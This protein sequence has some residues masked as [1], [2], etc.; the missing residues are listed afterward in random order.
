M[1][2]VFSFQKE[3]K[4]ERTVMEMLVAVVAAAGFY[5]FNLPHVHLYQMA[6]PVR[7][8]IIFVYHLHHADADATAGCNFH[9]D[10]VE[11]MSSSQLL[12]DRAQPTCAQHLQLSL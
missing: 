10:M 3:R 6:L 12:W 7:Y 5:M 11:T 2:N 1:A 8:E 4:K 9:L